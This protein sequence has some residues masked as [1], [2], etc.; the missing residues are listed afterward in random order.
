MQIAGGLG[1]WQRGYLVSQGAE[2]KLYSQL[3]SGTVRVGAMRKQ[4][5]GKSGLAFGA[6]GA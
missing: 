6:D 4:P 3:W 5:L 1:T 2:M